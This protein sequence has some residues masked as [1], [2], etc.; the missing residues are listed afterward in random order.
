MT[1]KALT[2]TFDPYDYE[3]MVKLMDE[4]GDSE[5]FYT[6]V[7]EALEDITI[8]ISKDRIDTTTF[9]SNGWVRK[10]TYWRDGTREELFEGKWDK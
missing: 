10:N 7:N 8:S 3:G 2:F 4:L 9:Q 1:E 5:T 6:G